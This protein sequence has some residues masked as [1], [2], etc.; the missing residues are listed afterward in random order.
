[1][2]AGACP[3]N[4]RGA[5]ELDILL[6]TSECRPFTLQDTLHVLRLFIKS[7]S[8]GAAVPRNPTFNTETDCI[9]MPDQIVVQGPMQ[10]VGYFYRSLPRPRQLYKVSSCHP[11]RSAAS[12]SHRIRVYRRR[13]WAR[14]TLRSNEPY[15]IDPAGVH[16][17][18]QN[19]RDHPGDSEREKSKPDPISAIP[20]TPPPTPC[21]SNTRQ[22]RISPL[23]LG[24]VSAA[25]LNNEPTTNVEAMGRPD[26]ARW[27]I[28]TNQKTQA[29]WGS[30]AWEVAVPPTKHHILECE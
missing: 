2:V 15:S 11:R 4:G 27:E 20:N 9:L 25:W 5:V 8:V 23:H 29:L 16:L 14:P 13:S 28:A 6:P 7:I 17:C 1:M 26:A 30:K 22:Q 19:K 21:L 18:V 24:L 12:R 10:K 3:N